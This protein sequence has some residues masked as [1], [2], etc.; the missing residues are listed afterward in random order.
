MTITTPLNC[1]TITTPLNWYTTETLCDSCFDNSIAFIKKNNT[2]VK[3]YNVAGIK[4]KCEEVFENSTQKMCLHFYG[5]DKVLN[6]ECSFDKTINIDTDIYNRYDWSV[7]NGI[8][9]VTLY[10]KINPRP[11]FKRVEKEAVKA[12]DSE[13]K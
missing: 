3:A 12:K 9:Y 4:I 1:D 10:E 7:K 6:V 11:D 2:F 8:L 13:E 5:K